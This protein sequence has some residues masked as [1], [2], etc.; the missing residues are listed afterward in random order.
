MTLTEYLE[1]NR[2]DCYNW[3]EFWQNNILV[4]NYYYDNSSSAFFAVRIKK[5]SELELYL[6]TD[7]TWLV[8]YL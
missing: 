2:F 4:Q 6:E 7:F 1:N 5:F 3:H 8:I